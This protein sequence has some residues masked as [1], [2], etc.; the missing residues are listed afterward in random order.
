MV[1]C[2]LQLYWMPEGVALTNYSAHLELKIETLAL[3]PQRSLLV[4]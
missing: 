1:R 4:C 2:I 3:R